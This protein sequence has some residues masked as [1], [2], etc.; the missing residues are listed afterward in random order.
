MTARSGNFKGNRN[1]FN[2]DQY[3]ASGRIL[4]PPSKEPA[5]LETQ[6]GSAEAEVEESG[7]GLGEM[8]GG[9]AVDDY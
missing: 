6:Q 5:K 9:A 2:L 8:F 3:Y 4:P 1:K 7:V